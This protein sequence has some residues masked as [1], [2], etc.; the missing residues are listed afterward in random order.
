MALDWLL[1]TVVEE[2]VDLLIV[3]GD[4]FDVSTPSNAAR[5]QYYNFLSRLTRTD[6]SG[7]V[8]IGGN[9]DS[10]LMLDAVAELARALSVHVIGAARGEVQE[11]IV[12][13]NC[14]E[15]KVPIAHVAAVPYLRERDVR[16]SNF[17]ESSEERLANLKEGIQH[18]YD[19]IAEETKNTR[20]EPSVPLIA[21]GHL[22]ASGAADD[23]GKASH[24][25]GADEH[26][27][28]VDHFDACFDYVA[29]GHVHRSQTL[30]EEG[31]VAYSGSI[32]PLS[33]QEAQSR[34]SVRIIDI[35]RAG[36]GVS[37]SKR[38]L[39]NARR[40]LRFRGSLG[41]VLAQL[42][43]ASEEWLAADHPAT[44]LRPWGEVKVVTDDPVPDLKQRLVAAMREVVGRAGELPIQLL[45]HNTVPATPR[46]LSDAG[47]ADT[48]VLDEIAPSEVFADVCDRR[49]VGE[50]YRKEVVGAFNDLLSYCQ[51]GDLL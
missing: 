19:R 47:V 31:R 50:D 12:T 24:I 44:A 37:V 8:I 20:R 33:F 6:C 49:G 9:H 1:T 28:E 22:F 26:N 29:L 45:F 51:E 7:V 46:A 16:S 21:T 36:G 14:K 18:H 30:D 32:V 48:R 15:R 2:A 17:G 11:Q 39:P 10:A 13:I 25:Y 5:Q 41:E 40:L 4:V 3:A 34:R 42:R 38:Y 43:K 23:S 27:I 35:E